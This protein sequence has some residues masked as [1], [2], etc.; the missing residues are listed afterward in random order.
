MF[1]SGPPDSFYARRSTRT[2]TF[3]RPAGLKGKGR[4]VMRIIISAA[5]LLGHPIACVLV[6]M[7][8]AVDSRGSAQQCDFSQV[9]SAMA[10]MVA[11]FA[12]L[13][14]AGIRIGTADE[15]LHEAY[16][17]TYDANTVVR[18]ASAAKLL[19]ASAV[20]SVVDDG[21]VGLDQAVD[22]LLPEF[23]G[24]SSSMT[25]RQMF[26]HTSGYPGLS[27]WPILGDDTVTLAQAVTTIATTIP[28][29]APPGTQFSYG[30]LSM[31]VGGR[32]VEVADGR[33]WD[34]LFAAR[35][36]IPLGM[37]ATDYEGLGVTDN[38]RIAG[39]ARTNMHDYAAVLEMLLRGG[40]NA[41]GQRVLSLAAVEEILADQRM[42]LPAI[43]VPDGI[44]EGGYGLGVWRE[45]FDASGNPIRISD[46]GAFGLTPWL[47]MDRRVYA[48]II[49]DFW[50]PF[51]L[52][53]LQTIQGFV[54]AELDNCNAQGP[55]PISV[56]L[57]SGL[58]RV[59][60]AMVLVAVGLKGA[61]RRR[62]KS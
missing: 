23:V 10:S 19:S 1:R 11:A 33:L 55:A 54:R 5:R 43:E 21:L 45:S 46:P 57:A 15:V 31:H 60:L 44:G 16:F 42:G 61:G 50:R 38:P 9:D 53:S 52:T 20:M 37:T 39:G 47:E 24:T 58:T 59:A 14:G 4:C 29:E 28:P 7:S 26:S 12:M 34:D 30:G 49:V 6:L 48:I 17:G 56:P 27:S 40:L 8:V 62:A 32:M 18:T 25:L 51:L 3:L 22:T 2:R 36:A 41:T 35:I 13:P